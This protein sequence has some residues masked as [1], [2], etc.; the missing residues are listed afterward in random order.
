VAANI[1]DNF[2]SRRL[3][4]FSFDARRLI[5]RILQNWSQECFPAVLNCYKAIFKL[6]ERVTVIPVTALFF[7]AR[8]VSVAAKENWPVFSKDTNIMLNR[9]CLLQKGSLSIFGGFM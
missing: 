8:P 7:F 2:F 4:S 1:S 5:F 6:H 9:E 3:G